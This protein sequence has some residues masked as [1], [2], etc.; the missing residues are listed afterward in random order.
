MGRILPLIP[1]RE[2]D[3]YTVEDIM[4]VWQCSRTS[5]YRILDMLEAKGRVLKVNS[6]R[7]VRRAVFEQWM[8][9]QDGY[10]FKS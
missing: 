6:M 4:R 5:A 1:A 8:A 2:P 9:E 3:I 7:R 10:C